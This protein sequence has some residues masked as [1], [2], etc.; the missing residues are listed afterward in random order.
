[1]V[2]GGRGDGRGRAQWV[3]VVRAVGQWW[4]GVERGGLAAR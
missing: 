2:G 3:G 4:H 1:V